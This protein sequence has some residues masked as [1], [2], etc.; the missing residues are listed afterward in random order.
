M[1]NL[2]DKLLQFLSNRTAHIILFCAYYILMVAEYV[3]FVCPYFPHLHFHW[4]YSAATVLWGVLL[5]VALALCIF[6]LKPSS[7]FAYALSVFAAALFG[8]PAIVFFQ[9]GGGSVF[10]CLYALL[11]TF[12]ISSRWLQ[13]PSFKSPVVPQRLQMPALLVLALLAL[14]PFILTYGTNLHFNAF[15]MGTEVYDAREAAQLHATALTAY[16][17][18]PLVKVLLPLL[19]VYGVWRR[20]GW[21]AAFAAVAMLY[22]FLVNPH[23][24]VVLSLFLVLAFCLF[25]D[26]NAKAGLILFGMVLMVVA[27]ALFTMV[28]GNILPESILV[29]RM[30]FTPAQLSSV[31]FAYFEHNHIYLSHSI[32]HHF[33]DYPYE[34]D[35]PHLIGYYMY[36]RANVSCNTGFIGDGYMN[37]GHW[38]ALAFT[39][40]TAAVFRFFECLKM[41]PVFFG[42]ILLTLFTFL[43]GAFLTSLLTHGVLFFILIALFFL[44]TD[45]DL[46]E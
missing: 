4:E 28:T 26:Y 15:S 22:I 35:P 19:L 41:R 44:K 25:D 46:K 43:N 18:G 33:F 37:F 13:I 2:K 20:N 24:S 36:G 11:F 7:S 45:K 23:K 31:Y 9:F 14:L 10:P 1:K 27:G 32:L 6:G 12:L 40:G 39:I 42:V 30:F 34:L 29:R 38:G 21:V 5:V 8:V 3:H 16:L 17:F